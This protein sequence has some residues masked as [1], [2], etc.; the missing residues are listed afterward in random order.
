MMKFRTKLTATLMMSALLAFA[1]AFVGCESGGS[2][3]NSS[4]NSS[5][6]SNDFVGG[7]KL[8]SG[9]SVWYLYVYTD[10]SCKLCDSADESKP[11]LSGTYSVSGSTFTG[12]M[13]NPGV[14]EAQIVAS[15]SSGTMSLDFIEHW[16]TPYKH[17][18][19]TGAKL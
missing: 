18:A 5:S 4:S 13:T 8:T 19:Y 15:L 10:G 2:D 11:H 16:H 9:S 1:F 17:I 6:S 14:G 12:N 7:W 3:S